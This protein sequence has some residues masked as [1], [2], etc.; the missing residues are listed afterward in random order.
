MIWI[1]VK[2]I[3]RVYI[4]VRK[5]DKYLDMK[6]L[7]DFLIGKLLLTCEDEILIT[8]ET[9]HDHIKKHVKKLIGLFPRFHW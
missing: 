2:M 8:T 7:I 3:I 6:N 4:K 9:S 5:I 1:L